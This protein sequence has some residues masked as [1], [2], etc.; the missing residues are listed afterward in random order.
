VSGRIGVALAFILSW[1]AVMP[2]DLASADGSSDTGA[3][4]TTLPGAPAITAV[5]T[6]PGATLP[7]GPSVTVAIPCTWRGVVA[8]EADADAYNVATIVVVDIINT[9]LDTN[10]VITVRYYSEDDRLHRWSDVRDRFERQQRADCSSATDRNGVSTGD[11]R[12][13]AATAPDPMILLAATTATAT[14]PITLPAPRISPPDRSPVNLGLWLAVEPVGPISV[15]AQL[16]PLWAETTATMVSTGFDPGNGDPTIVCAGHGTPIPDSHKNSIEQG[17]CGYTY[18]ADTDGGTIPM[19]ITSTW[20]V[21]WALSDGATG[22]QDDIVVST[23]VPY[24]VYEIQ[25]VGI[26]G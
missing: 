8:D 15:R 24:E 2:L 22:S 19:T 4:P 13:V 1:V 11:T 18:L 26:D 25:T 5:V 7:E 16:G 20:T 9:V 3:P 21:T 14:E 6:D 10:H 12:W 17:P 23:V